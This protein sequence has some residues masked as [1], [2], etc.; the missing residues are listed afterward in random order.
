MSRYS[1]EQRNGEKI[2]IYQSIWK[3]LPLAVGGLLFGLLCTILTKSDNPDSTGRLMGWFGVIFGIGGGAIILLGPILH[4]VLHTPYI[5]IH[6]DRVDFYQPF[7][8][9]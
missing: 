7:K 1:D 2:K 9:T 8:Y 4:R 6:N 5:I 3:I